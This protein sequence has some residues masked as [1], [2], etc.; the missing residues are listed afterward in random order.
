MDIRPFADFLLACL[1]DLAPELPLLVRQ[2][3][4][5][6]T[7]KSYGV[8]GGE[9]EIEG[10]PPRALVAFM[11]LKRN[12]KSGPAWFPAERLAEYVLTH[13]R[14]KRE[15]TAELLERMRQAWLKVPDK[16]RRL[17]VEERTQNK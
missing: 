10:R 7:A 15:L 5:T 11:A 12:A 2:W 1:P 13:S 14:V 17:D 4:L 3:T 16:Y 8:T 9:I 6:E